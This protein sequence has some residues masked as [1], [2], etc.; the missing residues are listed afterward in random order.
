MVRSPVWP[1]LFSSHTSRPVLRVCACSDRDSRRFKHVKPCMI[2]TSQDMC[3]VTSLSERGMGRGQLSTDT[4]YGLDGQET[5]TEVEGESL[6]RSLNTS[7]GVLSA[8]PSLQRSHPVLVRTT[9]PPIVQPQRE[10]SFKAI[11]EPRM[12]ATGWHDPNLPP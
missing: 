2:S 10:D 9:D 3:G 6:V 1:Y 11:S 8:K 12:R 5:G 7:T 4:M